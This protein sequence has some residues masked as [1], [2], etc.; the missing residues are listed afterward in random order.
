[1]MGAMEPERESAAAGASAG[2]GA[3][4]AG[5]NLAG[6]LDATLGLGEAARQVRS[7]VEAAGALVAPLPLAHPS[8]PREAAGSTTT[9]QGAPH[10]VTLVCATPDG[11][12]GARAQLPGAAWDD[13]QVIGLWWWEVAQVP[14]RWVRAFDGVDEVWAGSRFV[15]ELLAAVSPVP[16][17][18][19]PLPVA[20]PPVADVTRAQLGLPET[21]FLVGFA[22]DHA[23][24]LGRKNPLGLIEAFARAFPEDD[25][26]GEQL[27]VKTLGGDRHPDAH[28]QLLA[29][30]ARHPRVHVVDRHLT[31]PEKNALIAHL[32]AYVSL[33]RAEGFGLT[34]A[35]A[36]L[37]GT[38]VVATDYGGSRDF[39]TSF[40]GWPVDHRPVAIGPGS[41]PYP[42]TGEWAEPDLDHAAAV[43]REL[44]AQP[45]EVAR[46][47][48]RARQEVLR[49]HAPAAAGAA[50]VDRLL[51]RAGLPR[52]PD[53]A[54]DPLDLDAVAQRVRTGPG[55]PAPG[56]A[57]GPRQAARTALLRLL[58][59]YAVHQR[60][61]DEELLRTLRTLD[62][63]V[64]AV[65][66]GQAALAA[67]LRR[68]EREAR[69]DAAGSDDR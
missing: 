25:H 38:P 65:A 4:V 41:D 66:A 26:A 56:A 57:G 29:A 68:R 24:T 3:G 42:A 18:R 12:A 33:H 8:A 7:A 14:G 21:G 2:A 31:G 60:L 62:E 1:M 37:L 43:L 28:A 59:P 55:A 40:T 23:S 20:E 6:Y 39:V 5:V 44:R 13:R 67:E 9:A 64:R 34:L 47:A 58:K 19:M 53:G 27:V 32:D 10:P 51:V 54:I 17:V 35:E 48:A 61:V 11:M 36:M 63:R 46:R 16:V 45:Q 50:M 49:E 15:A 30:A 22:F 69:G 52:R